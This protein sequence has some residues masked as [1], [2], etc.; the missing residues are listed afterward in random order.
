[1]SVTTTGKRHLS[2]NLRRDFQPA[3]EIQIKRDHARTK[4]A[5]GKRNCCFF[6]TLKGNKERVR[7]KEGM[8]EK[9]LNNTKQKKKRGEK[10][11]NIAS[12]L[13]K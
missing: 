8:R 9:I 6:D 10:E 13:W 12:D 4:S 7:V 3:S 11:N 2:R 5:R 1:V